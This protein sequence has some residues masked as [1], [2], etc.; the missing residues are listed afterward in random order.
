MTVKC[1]GRVCPRRGSVL[2]FF[3][4]ICVKVRSSG[5][6]H[7]ASTLEFVAER[8]SVPVPR[9]Y[10]AFSHKGS[11]YM[12]MERIKGDMLGRTWSSRSVESRAKI[13]SQLKS[14]VAEMRSVLPQP[15]QGVSNIDGGPIWD[16]RIP[17]VS[18]FHGPFR[19]VSE[20]HRHLRGGFEYHPDHFQDMNTLISLQDRC[21]GDPVLTH[22]DLSS[23]NILVHE[24]QVVG[25]IDWETAGW[26]PSYWE[27]TSAW[28]VNPRNYFWRDEIDEFLEPMPIALEMENIRTKYFGDT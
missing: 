25:I 4:K 16:C 9:V 3:D 24:D 23:L 11:S 2:F 20:F 27:Y 1:L 13:L 6:L 18:M 12:V 5:H 14:M 21:W 7:E 10:C 19:T 17:G 28:R 26:Y 22:G 15:G 8:T